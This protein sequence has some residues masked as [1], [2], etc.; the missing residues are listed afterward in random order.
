MKR[1][2]ILAATA[3]SAAA[4]SAAGCGGSSAGSAAKPVDPNGPEVSPAGDIPDDQA[5][6]AYAPVGW[7]LSVEVPEGWARTTTA[8][9]ATFTDKLNSVTVD[10]PV[11]ATSA[12]T[13]AGATATEIPRL[14]RTV[15]GFG[16]ARATIVTRTAGRALRIA[17]LARSVPDAVTGTTRRNAVERY[18]LFRSGRRAVLT[19]AGPEGADNVDPWKIVTDS[20]RWTR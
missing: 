19:L 11:A 18:E 10:R 16:G 8:T 2:A 20:F 14:A 1:L 6:V 13:V 3:L 4:L 5:F 7:G 12:P 17:Y 15:T 9:T